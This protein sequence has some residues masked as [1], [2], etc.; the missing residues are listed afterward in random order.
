MKVCKNRAAAAVLAAL[1]CA[2]P[3]AALAGETAPLT[4]RT[5]TD[6]Q[7]C[8]RR[9]DAGR[10]ASLGS[11]KQYLGVSAFD[12]WLYQARVGGLMLRLRLYTKDGEGVTFKE[13]LGKAET[14]G[15]KDIRLCLR[16]S[17]REGGLMLQMDQHALDVLARVGVT[18]IVVADADKYVQARYLVND[19]LDMR[20]AL[21]LKPGEQLSVCGENEP[22][23]VVSEDGVRR[24]IAQ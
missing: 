16:Q 13:Y 12:G 9:E 17:T 14:E 7:D 10:L 3:V 8:A 21:A 18:E 11:Q 15:K 1:M 5:Q 6:A 23:T 19:L 2:A 4:L 22:V 20:E 24:Q